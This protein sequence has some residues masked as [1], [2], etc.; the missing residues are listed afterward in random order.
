VKATD[1]RAAADGSQERPERRNLERPKLKE[2]ATLTAYRWW[3]L[4]PATPLSADIEGSDL[5]AL[6]TIRLNAAG[7]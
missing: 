2:D 3:H 7:L 5:A 6:F 1:A 4:G